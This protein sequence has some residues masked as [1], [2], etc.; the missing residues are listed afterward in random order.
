MKKEYI[1]IL[2][3]AIGLYLLYTYL[4]KPATAQPTG[5]TASALSAIKKLTSGGTITSSDISAVTT[6]VSSL[7]N[8]KSTQVI[9]APIDST[10]VIP[11][12]SNDIASEQNQPADDMSDIG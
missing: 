6:T 11:G 8:Q 7:L 12:S 4:S 3:G 1:I 10:V 5:T 2:I 9:D